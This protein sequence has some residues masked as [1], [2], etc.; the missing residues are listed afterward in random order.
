MIALP[1]TEIE[2]GLAVTGFIAAPHY[3]RASRKQITVIINGRVVRNYQVSAALERGYGS[4]MPR[5]RYPVAVLH[6]R[7]PP[8]RLDVNVH[9][10]KA[11]VRFARSDLIHDLVFKAVRSALHKPPQHGAPLHKSAA[12]QEAPVPM[13]GF[14]WREGRQ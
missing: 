9:P 4:F 6:L 12:E 10:A 13:P 3:N 11:E 1:E 14:F 8:D 2:P 7:I 5:Q